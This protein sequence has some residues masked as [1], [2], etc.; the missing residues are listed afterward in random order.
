MRKR[1]SSMKIQ[2]SK[3]ENVAEGWSSMS[4]CA[5]RQ[6][7]A[8]VRGEAQKDKITLSKAQMLA[9]MQHNGKET[10]WLR[11]ECGALHRVLH[12]S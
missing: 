11:Q 6:A 2:R 3:L 7:G 9:Q 5:C 8:S 12:S 4:Y 10:L 1:V